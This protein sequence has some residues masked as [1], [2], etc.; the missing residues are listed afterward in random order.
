MC[1]ENKRVMLQKAS[2]THEGKIAKCQLLSL[3]FIQAGHMTCNNAY[4]VLD[5]KTVVTQHMILVIMVEQNKQSGSAYYC[6]SLFIYQQ[7]I[8]KQQKSVPLRILVLFSHCIL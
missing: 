1:R 5:D 7:N 2:I 4:S 6:F 8:I 3:S